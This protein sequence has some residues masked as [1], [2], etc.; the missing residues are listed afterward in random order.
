MDRVAIY[1]EKRFETV[2]AIAV[3]APDPITPS[4]MKITANAV[5]LRKLG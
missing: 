2:I 1:D 3:Q 4:P 5:Q